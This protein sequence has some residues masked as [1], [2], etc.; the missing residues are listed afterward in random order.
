MEDIISLFKLISIEIK[1]IL[2]QSYDNIE[3]LII[4]KLCKDFKNCDK[5]R[6]FVN[7]NLDCIQYTNYKKAP[8]LISF[9]IIDNDN[10]HFPELSI[11]FG[12]FQYGNNSNK[13]Y[14][15]K[16]LVGSLYFIYSSKVQ[17]VYAN[18][19]GITLSILD[20]SKKEYSNSLLNCFSKDI[21]Y[22]SIDENNQNLWNDF[23]IYQFVQLLRENHILYY[24]ENIIGDLHCILINGGVIIRSSL[25]NK[26]ESDVFLATQAIPLAYI[27]ER[28]GGISHDGKQSL[29][30]KPFPTSKNIKKKTSFIAG[31]KNDLNKLLDILNPAII[32][33]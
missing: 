20:E 29:L 23:Y 32:S 22:Y 16:N 26:K 27:I 7:E 17:L 33:F 9:S 8:Y 30:D 3:E 1:N 21:K 18:H 14:D 15:G 11:V 10:S 19:T 2:L 6:T 28:G 31:S 4:N 24:T 25:A 5:I 13:I 12:I